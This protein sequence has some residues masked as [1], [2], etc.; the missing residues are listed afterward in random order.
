MLEWLPTC[1][2]GLTAFCFL[3]FY[4]PLFLLPCPMAARAVEL[5]DRFAV[6]QLLLLGADPN[7]KGQQGKTALHRAEEVTARDTVGGAH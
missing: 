4:F 7:T 2:V 1:M 3:C 6:E 5:D